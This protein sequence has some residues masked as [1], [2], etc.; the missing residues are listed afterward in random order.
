MMRL[1]RASVIVPLVLLAS[2]ATADAECAWVLWSHSRDGGT[3]QNPIPSGT[4]RILPETLSPTMG[5]RSLDECETARSRLT[6]ADRDVG[7]RAICLP[8][9]VDP[10]GPT[11]GGR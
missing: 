7:L 4:G 1:R 9:T 2:A 8:D 10:R 6:K 3:I 11:V 5:A